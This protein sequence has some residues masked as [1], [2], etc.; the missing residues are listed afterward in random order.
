M[1]HL[2]DKHDQPTEITTKRLI[3]VAQSKRPSLQSLALQ[4]RQRLRIGD[5]LTHAYRAPKPAQP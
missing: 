3:A 5:G 2:L 4:R 1:K